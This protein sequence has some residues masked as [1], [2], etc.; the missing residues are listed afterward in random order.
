MSNTHTSLFKKAIYLSFLFISACG[1]IHSPIPIQ[2]RI[3]AAL[4]TATTFIPTVTET[5]GLK[6][7]DQAVTIHTP[8]PHSE[9]YIIYSKYDASNDQEEIW[10]LSPNRTNPFLVTTNIIPRAWS[11]SNKLWL[12]TV[13]GSIYIANADGSS[14][15]AVYNNKEYT[16]VDP[17]WLTDNIVLFNAYRDVFSPPDIHNLDIDTGMVTKLF[18]GDNKFIQA[19]F[20]SEST[21]LRGDWLTGSLDIIN[22]NGEA[23]KFFNDFAILA[24]YFNP[25]QIQRINTLDKY[26]IVAKGKGDSNYK[27]WLVS[28]NETPKMLFDPGNEG[29]NFFMVSPDEQYLALTYVAAKDTFIYILNLEKQQ[30]AYTWHCPY[31]IGSCDFKWSP[32]SQSITLL[33]SDADVGTSNGITSGIQVMDIMTGETRKILKEDVTQIIAWHFIE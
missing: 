23:E 11:P 5:S 7:N 2:T 3:P 30:L 14:I 17:F 10:A 1:N 20:P 22:Q 25:Y 19:T 18:P 9:E 4:S 33:Y 28:N 15:R 26:L 6:G 13:D 8:L 27:F 21:W 29:V 12:F 24:D 31:E 16:G 32:D